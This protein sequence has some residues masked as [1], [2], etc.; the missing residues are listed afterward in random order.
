[1]LA[2]K[3]LLQMKYSRVVALFADQQ[4]LSMEEAL[5]FFYHSVTYR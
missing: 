5:D 4:E 3:T 1:M 2:D